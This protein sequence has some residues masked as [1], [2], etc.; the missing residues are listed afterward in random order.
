MSVL[1]QHQS[2]I[3]DQGIS[4]P[5]HGNE[6]VGGLNAIGKRYMYQLMSTIKLPLSKK[7]IHRL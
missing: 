3:F 7:L 6:V 2:I 4:A 5:G 1:S